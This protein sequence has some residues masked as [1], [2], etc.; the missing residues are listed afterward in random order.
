LG[1]YPTFIGLQI[2][3]GAKLLPQLRLAVDSSSDWG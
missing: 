2:G 1:K 3:H